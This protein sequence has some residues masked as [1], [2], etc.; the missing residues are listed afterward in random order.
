MMILIN[1]ENLTDKRLRPYKFDNVSQNEQLKK[2]NR[3]VKIQRA[4]WLLKSLFIF[5]SLH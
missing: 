5:I 3:K 1:K 4:T 2:Y